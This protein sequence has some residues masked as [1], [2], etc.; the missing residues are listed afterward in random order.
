MIIGVT[1]KLGAGKGEFTKYLATK[2]YTPLAFGEEVRKEA[3]S[4]E[5]KPTR[6][7]LQNLGY[8]LRE[9]KPTCP[10][11]SRLTEKIRPENNY[12]VDGFRYPD[13]I[14]L[15]RE[16]F[17]FFYLVGIDAEEE[18][19]YQR[20]KDRGR[21]GDPKNWQ[22]FWVQDGMDRIGYLEEK[23]QNT[24][25]CFSHIDHLIKNNNDLE[26]FKYQID[27]VMEE[28]FNPKPKK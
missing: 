18:I 28:I 11:V 4:R 7:N 17:K 8:N 15:F 12:V 6:E 3:I 14:R 24:R 9:N 25:G 20:L 10:W 22:E 21:E 13:Q 27:K 16:G 5:I 26:Y 19:R 2:R 23:G 1:G